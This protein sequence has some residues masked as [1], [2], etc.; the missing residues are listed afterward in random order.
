MKII[1]RFITVIMLTAISIM[2]CA[3][4]DHDK[5]KRLMEDGNI[6]PLKTILQKARKIQPGKI[7]EVELENKKGKRIYEV[8]LLTTEGNV[9]ELKFNARTGTHIS[10]EKED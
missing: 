2:A 9:I 1:I 6:L 4:D 10:T 7:L 8:E 5:A 3:D